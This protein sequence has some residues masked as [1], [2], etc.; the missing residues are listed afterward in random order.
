[1]RIGSSTGSGNWFDGKIDEVRVS[2]TAHTDGYIKTV[3]NN[4]NAPG[5]FYSLSAEENLGTILSQLM[6]VDIH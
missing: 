3:Y 5:T 2:A 4:T 1:M 6:D